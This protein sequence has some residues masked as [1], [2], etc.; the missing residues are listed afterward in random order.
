MS[1]PGRL[2]GALRIVPEA[3][4]RLSP[5]VKLL[6]AI[7]RQAE[8]SGDHEVGEA[9]RIVFDQVELVPQFELIHQ[10]VCQ[11]RQ[12]FPLV[13]RNRAGAKRRR[14]ELA[15]DPMAIP[16]HRDEALT[17][18]GFEGVPVHQMR[19]KTLVVQEGLEQR[20]VAGN[21]EGG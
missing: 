3:Q 16:L 14:R 10:L 13:A 7:S 6:L 1:S 2:R 11:R 17:D 21:D 4:Q 9:R 8:Q 20:V 5:L 12:T 19:R 15:I 18:G